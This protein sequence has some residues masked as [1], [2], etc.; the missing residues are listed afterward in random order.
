MMTPS[1]HRKPQL[2]RA[3]LQ[4]GV[5]LLEAMIATVILALGLLGAI[6]MQARAYSTMADAGMRAEAT[7]A[8]EKLLSI[9]TVDQASALDYAYIGSGA[10]SARLAGWLAETRAAIPG[11][12]VKVEVA[13]I[14]PTRR[15]VDVTITWT[16]KQGSLPSTHQVRGFVAAS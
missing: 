3:R 2:P 5:A 11:A 15:Q 4:R 16:R 6:G 9:M 14:N 7:M 1:A 12:F 8:S 13:T 10:A